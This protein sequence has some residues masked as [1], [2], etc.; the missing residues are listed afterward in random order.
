[1][2]ILH[3]ESSS[4]TIANPFRNIVFQNSFS[5]SSRNIM[6][7]VSK[8]FILPAKGIKEGMGETL[9]HVCEKNNF[10]RNR[11]KLVEEIY[12]LEKNIGRHF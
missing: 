8:K 1:M 5:F 2:L 6:R 4:P 3:F 7:D 10:K 11:R 9:S 12:F